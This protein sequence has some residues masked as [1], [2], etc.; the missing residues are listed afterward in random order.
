MEMSSACML[1]ST[2]SWVVGGEILGPVSYY[3]HSISGYGDSH[4]KDKTVDRLTLNMGI[5]VLSRQHLYIETTSCFLGIACARYCIIIK[6]SRQNDFFDVFVHL[7][8]SLQCLW[9][10]YI[11]QYYLPR[12]M[13][14]ITI[15]LINCPPNTFT[16]LPLE[17]TWIF[18]WTWKIF[19]CHKC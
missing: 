16:K 18:I 1:T 11:L 10:C 3:K 4:V 9:W 12:G 19:I 5:P 6:K 17:T 7:L 2:N 14:N 15:R 13:I 8:F